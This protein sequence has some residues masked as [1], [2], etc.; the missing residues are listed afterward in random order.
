M[1]GT[2]TY[3]VTSSDIIEGVVEVFPNGSLE[4]FTHHRDSFQPIAC[5]KDQNSHNQ[6][7]HMS[8]QIHI[9]GDRLK[10]N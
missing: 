8:K 1:D 9:F 3:R 5:R 10:A 7:N 2:G 4:R 6:H